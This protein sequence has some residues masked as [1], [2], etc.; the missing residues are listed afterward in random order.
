LCGNSFVE[1]RTLAG[2]SSQRDD[3]NRRHSRDGKH[4]INEEG[5][6]KICRKLKE[7]LTYDGQLHNTG[8]AKGQDNKRTPPPKSLDLY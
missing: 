1:G 5:E 6:A 7:F 3:V 8:H 2:E 4:T